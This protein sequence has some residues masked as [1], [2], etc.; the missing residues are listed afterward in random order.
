V[1][2]GDAFGTKSLLLK[3]ISSL[4]YSYCINGRY[5]LCSMNTDTNT[6]VSL[7]FHKHN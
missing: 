1:A 5:L 4:K 6:E 7:S 3:D 2:D